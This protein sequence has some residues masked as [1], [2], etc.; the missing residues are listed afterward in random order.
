M[1]F[2]NGSNTNFGNAI[3]I[4]PNSQQWSFYG[5]FNSA[6]SAQYYSIYLNKGES[7][8]VFLS[9]PS[10]QNT[11]S[12]PQLAL[13]GPSLNSVKDVSPGLYVPLG[14]GA[15]F[16]ADSTTAPSNY[17]PVIPSETNILVSTSLTAY[18]NST[19]YIAVFNGQANSTYELSSSSNYTLTPGDWITLSAKSI[20]IYAWE[21]EPLWFVL[22]PIVLVFI[23]GQI[24][25]LKKYWGDWN[26]LS[27]FRFWIIIFAA[28]FLFGCSLTMLMQALLY[29]YKTGSFNAVL[30]SAVPI[31][32]GIILGILAL[33]VPIDNESNRQSDKSLHSNSLILIGLL[34][35]ISSTGFMAGPILAILGAVM[36]KRIVATKAHSTMRKASISK[37]PKRKSTARKIN[38]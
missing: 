29:V 1:L 25:V 35:I 36:P 4:S 26:K 37:T 11:S 17:N 21:Q 22:L 15:V 14:Y 33:M 3:P 5:K 20:G 16:P 34:G 38:R 30:I 7:V 27:N 10:N 23:V 32:I 8:G 6:G 24:A 31:L 9:V 19:Y 13:I 18:Q 28:I 2:I 12:Y